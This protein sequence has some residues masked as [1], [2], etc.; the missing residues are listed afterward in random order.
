MQYQSGQHVDI[1]F[2]RDSYERQYDA[3][4]SLIIEW[5]DRRPDKWDALSE[6]LGQAALWVLKVLGSDF[7]FADVL[8]SNLKGGHE[9]QGELENCCQVYAPRYWLGTVALPT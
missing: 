6:E 1:P 7:V 8:S 5:C 9:N 2:S 4:H 3:F